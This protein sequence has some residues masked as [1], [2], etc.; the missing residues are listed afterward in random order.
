[1]L[2]RKINITISDPSKTMMIDQSF[3]IETSKEEDN[4]NVSDNWKE[5]FSSVRSFI[6]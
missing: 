6:V 4:D 5:K 1:M 2:A 3:I